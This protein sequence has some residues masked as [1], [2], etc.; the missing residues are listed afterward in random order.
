MLGINCSLGKPGL[1]VMEEY[2]TNFVNE[3]DSFPTK[4]CTVKN[5]VSRG[6]N[7]ESE[8]FVPEHRFSLSGHNDKVQDRGEMTSVSLT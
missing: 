3:A 4:N 6:T 2:K 8:E 7:N 5:I 1:L